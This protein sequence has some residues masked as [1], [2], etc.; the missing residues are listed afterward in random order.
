[1]EWLNEIRPWI[2]PV[3]AIVGAGFAA[4]GKLRSILLGPLEASIERIEK[5]IEKL[6]GSIEK[7]DEKLDMSIQRLEAKMDRNHQ[8]LKA[9]HKSLQELFTKHLI[10]LH[11]VSISDATGDAD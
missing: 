7:L 1:M 2:V 8:E 6:E 3:L 11:G 5:S 9:D 4:T 10:E